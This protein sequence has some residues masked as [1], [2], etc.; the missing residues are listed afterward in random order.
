MSNMR[1]VS[2]QLGISDHKVFK[3]IQ[4]RKLSRNDFAG[5]NNPFYGK[6]H[7]DAFKQKISKQNSGKIAVNRGRSKYKSTKYIPGLTVNIWQRGAAI[8]NI[9]WTISDNDLD[10]LWEEQKGLCALTQQPMSTDYSANKYIGISLDRIDSN[11]GYI[12]GNIQLVT[13]IV[14]IC[15]NILNNNDFIELCKKVVQANGH[16]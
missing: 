5:S 11:K 1:A 8:R 15:K 10:I 4:S 2:K 3:V 14:N 7:S 9:E 6:K 12:K 13:G 16:R